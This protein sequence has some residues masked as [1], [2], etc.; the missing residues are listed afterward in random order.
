[1]ENTKFTETNV[2]DEMYENIIK[3]LNETNYG[4]D[5]RKHAY[6]IW[7]PKEYERQKERDEWSRKIYDDWSQQAKKIKDPV[8]VLRE[9]MQEQLDEIKDAIRKLGILLDSD[10]PT[11]EQLKKHKILR[12]AYKKYKMVE[13]LVL[14]KGKEE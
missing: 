4:N 2:M 5:Q 1:M 6:E 10:A 12:D 3:K 11:E 14:G 9:E 7:K 8:T 13:A